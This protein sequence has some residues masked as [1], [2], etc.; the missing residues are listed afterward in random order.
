MVELRDADGFWFDVVVNGQCVAKLYRLLGQ[1]NEE[2][3]KEWIQT[4]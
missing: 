4:L 1:T 3:F 2:A